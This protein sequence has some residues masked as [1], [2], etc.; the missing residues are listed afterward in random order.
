MGHAASVLRLTCAPEDLARLYPWLDAAAAQLRL[1][2]PTIFAMHVALEE[3]VAN[4]AMHGFAPGDAGE[5][6]VRLSTDA[7]DAVLVV[8]D[9][10]RPFDL[11]AAAPRPRPARLEDARP[12]GLG[13][14]LVR[15][16][17]QA[18]DYERQGNC[19]RLTMRFAT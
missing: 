2:A 10:G 19:N 6:C 7:D 16:Y 18:L 3:V 12:G 15:H 1:P 17:C 8:E 14:S 4:A 5:I 11:T 13:L 9:T